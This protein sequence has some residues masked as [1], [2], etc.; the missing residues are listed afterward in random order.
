M[1][2]LCKTEQ[3]ALRQRELE[4]ALAG[5][6]L[7]HRYE[8]ITVSEFCSYAGIPRKA[9]YRYFSSKDGALY[10]L[11]DH[12]M[13]EYEHFREP[14]I[15]GTRRSSLKELEGFF[16]FWIRQKPVLDALEISGLSGVLLERA[17]TSIEKNALLRKLLPGDSEFVQRQILRFTVSGTMIM[18]VNWHHE[19]FRESPRE[20]AELT[21][22][23][24]NEPLFPYVRD[25][26]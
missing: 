2:K 13:L 24:L 26:I 15:A 21:A 8:D 1:Y 14:R 6:M 3:S 17:I 10:A 5:M 22:R 4:L 9:F 16:Q 20:M 11:I 25:L 12:T 19:G 7:L 23:M 18:M